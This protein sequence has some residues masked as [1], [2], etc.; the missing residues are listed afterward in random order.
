MNRTARQPLTIRQEH[1]TTSTYT[2]ER[3]RGKADQQLPSLN[4]SFASGV[5][6]LCLAIILMTPTLASV[7]MIS[8]ALN[9][10]ANSVD[11]VD[12]N[13]SFIEVQ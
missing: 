10:Y 5:I 12:R 2:T 11:R 1:I 9:S 6:Q 3:S 4:F 8:I 7:S 13:R